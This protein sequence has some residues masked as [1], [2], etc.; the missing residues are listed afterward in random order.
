MGKLA[1]AEYPVHELIEKRWSPRA[2]ADR[3]VDA[4][5]LR[6]LFEA[7]RWGPSCYNEQPWHF[8]VA[9][10]DQPA[11][12]EHLL[13]CLSPGNQKWA[14]RAPVL[15]LTVAR[16]EFSRDG[17]PN[18]HALHDVGLAMSQLVLQA[19]A[20]GLVVHQMGGFD[21]ERAREA[22]GIPDGYVA[23]A[24]VA[25]GY[26]GE[27]A[28]LDEQLQRREVAPRQRR[29]QRSFVFGGRW[30]ESLVL[31]E[32]RGSERVLSFWFGQLDEQGRASEE[33]AGRWWR[34]DAAFDQQIR[35]EFGAD[36][37][38]IL[39]G[40]REDWL[41]SPRG[42]L[43]Y[44]I[45]LDQFSRNMYRDTPQMFAADDWALR[46]ALEGIEQGMDR[47][48]TTDERVF[49][50]M[51]L[52]HSEALKI[53]DRSVEVFSAYCNEVDSELQQRI[54]K[55]LDFAVRHRDIIERW[56]RFPHRN[57]ILGRESTAEE[58]AFLEQPNSSF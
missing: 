34:K 7:S 28:S 56:G 25:I 44:I 57:A 33:T 10:L 52:M 39:A 23:V 41:K 31:R 48:L 51:P 9:T 42:R 32:E 55:N 17:K 35:E 43:A 37:R 14:R 4:Q 40:E 3:K 13:A 47:F 18:R 36:H 24:A 1:A 5:T 26:R 2:F 16:L 53:Q 15:A 30:G 38:A 58:L 11:D 54:G 45:V 46:A 29:P 49:F 50:Y 27:L 21:G 6:T 22:F 20:L 12:F 8:I 19:T